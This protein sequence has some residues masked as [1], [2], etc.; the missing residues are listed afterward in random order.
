MELRQCC[1]GAAHFQVSPS[2]GTIYRVDYRSNRLIAAIAE[3]G[4]G[5]VLEQAELDEKA[6][7]DVETE[8]KGA[9]RNET[10][11]VETNQVF[12]SPP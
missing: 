4:S 9:L 8:Q 1:T 3:R 12:Y 5:P 11:L 7:G 2:A 10:E 6:G